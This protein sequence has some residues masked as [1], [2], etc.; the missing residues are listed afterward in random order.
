MELALTFGSWAPDLAQVSSATVV[1]KLCW[2]YENH[3]GYLNTWLSFTRP[4]C[5]IWLVDVIHAHNAWF[6]WWHMTYPQTVTSSK[7]I[8][9]FSDTEKSG[10]HGLKLPWQFRW[11]MSSSQPLKHIAG[12]S[13][14]AKQ[15]KALAAKIDDLNR[16][17]WIYMGER[18]E[19]TPESCPLTLRH[20]WWHVC[21]HTHSK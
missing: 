2:K 5:L 9:W 7:V 21:L 12:T 19:E 17:P 6:D 16:M 15:V 11:I 18:R 3:L 8:L 20:S 4:Q 10:N 14:V 13:E 1:V